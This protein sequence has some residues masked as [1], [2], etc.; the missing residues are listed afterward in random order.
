MTRAC[1]MPAYEW[2]SKKS[3]WTRALHFY[4][5]SA[6]SAVLS[7]VLVLSVN[8][9]HFGIMSKRLDRS[10]FFHHVAA[11]LRYEISTKFFDTL[12]CLMAS[13]RPPTTSASIDFAKYALS[14]SVYLMLWRVVWG[15]YG[16]TVVMCKWQLVERLITLSLVPCRWNRPTATHGCCDERGGGGGKLSHAQPSATAALGRVVLIKAKTINEWVSE[17]V[18]GVCVRRHV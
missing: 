10:K 13:H 5:A 6:C 15:A 14:R 1:V 9:S 12:G 4:R 18:S 3:L 17:W 16:Y 11:S 8:P 2:P 7:A